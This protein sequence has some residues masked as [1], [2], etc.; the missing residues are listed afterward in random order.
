VG[1]IRLA[2]LLHDVGKIG[3]PDAVLRKEAPL[4]AAEGDMIRTHSVVG[5]SIVESAGLP[6]EARW[7]R[8][9]HERL[10][11]TG[12]PDRIGAEEL[13]LESR[14]IFVA[15]VFEAITADR[16]YRK[17]RSADEALAELE[18]NAGTWFDPECVAAVRRVVLGEAQLAA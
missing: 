17:A 7:I 11:G 2:G 4:D 15:D 13:P 3:I 1:R 10:D 16:P 6:E 18:R 9:H 8:H 5:E 12:Y 14:I